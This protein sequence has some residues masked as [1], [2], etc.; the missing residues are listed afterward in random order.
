MPAGMAGTPPL[1][2]RS[3]VRLPDEIET[4]LAGNE[5]ASARQVHNRRLACSAIWSSSRSA[6]SL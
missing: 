4:I 5:P 3:S 6:T 2:C 1:K